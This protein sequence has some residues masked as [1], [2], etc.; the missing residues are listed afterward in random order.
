MAKK[1]NLVG[2]AV[3]LSRRR[4]AEVVLGNGNSHRK[5][6]NK[7][8]KPLNTP[9]EGTACLVRSGD[10]EGKINTYKHVK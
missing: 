1:Q 5:E 7:P 9:K 2:S 6:N 10:R 8:K 3:G 4:N